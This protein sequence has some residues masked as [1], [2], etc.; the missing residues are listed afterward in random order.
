MKISSSVEKLYNS[1]IEEYKIIKKLAD[2]K[3]PS[4]INNTWHYDGRIKT[5][6]SFAQKVETGR[7]SKEEIFEDMFACRI[8]VDNINEVNKLKEIIKKTFKCIITKPMTNKSTHKKPEEFPF[9]DLRLYCKWTDTPKR[10]DEE[11]IKDLIFEIQIKTY[12]QHA[13]GI[14]THSLIYK[15]SE[16]NWKLHRIAFQV[17]AILEHAEISIGSAEEL[18]KTDLLPRENK[19]FKQYEQIR[20]I[21]EYYWN[22]DTLPKDKNRL[23]QNICN[24]LNFIKMNSNEYK[25]LLN[26]SID[27]DG[28]ITIHN[29]SP[30][31]ATLK[32]LNDYE[33]DKLFDFIKDPKNKFIDIDELE[34]S[35]RINRELYP[36]NFQNE[37]IMYHI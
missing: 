36:E 7:F 33:N 34:L 15:G 3:I 11:T 22:N 26:K 2:G 19:E 16:M 21:L 6:E 28:K 5:L 1:K 35:E 17:K 24:V 13:W 23:I 12:L 32:L 20:K 4:L 31:Y 27:K 25:T 8:V 9:D 18:A 10:P 14:A 29:L 30:Y 37:E